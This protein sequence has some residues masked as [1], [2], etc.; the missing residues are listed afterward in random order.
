MVGPIV[1][2]LL[3]IVIPCYNEEEVLP[4]TARQL[5]ALLERLV[6]ASEADPDSGIWFVDDGSRDR[7]WAIISELHA[8]QPQRFHGIKLSRNQ[9]HQN[10]L[11][12]GLWNTPGDAL[13][14]IDADLQDDIEAIP[15]MLALYHQG[16]DIVYGVRARRDTDTIFKRRTARTYYSL[17]KQLGVEIVADHADYRLMSRRSVEALKHYGEVNLFLRAI[18]PRLGFKVAEVTYERKPRFA[19]TS[20]YPIGRMLALALNGITS[21]SMG[22]LRLITVTG[23]VMAVVSFMIGVWGIFL[24]LFT[25]RTVPGWAS[26]YFSD[27]C[28]ILVRRAGMVLVLHTE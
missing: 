5:S 24:A 13:I 12:A 20:K 26:A 23:F 2:P 27:A 28:R 6:T 16:C 21:F 22:P 3:N 10:A 4:E 9:G 8:S 15:K 14:S 7:T 19:G 18:I 25:N 1:M 11:I 17:L